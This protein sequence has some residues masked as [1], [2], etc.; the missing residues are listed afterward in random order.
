MILYPAWLHRKLLLSYRCIVAHGIAS[1][2]ASLAMV[3]NDSRIGEIHD[4]FWVIIEQAVGLR[5]TVYSSLSTSSLVKP[6]N[7]SM[8]PTSP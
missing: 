8:P 2:A 3:I 5:S 1:C 6:H 4:A 7:L